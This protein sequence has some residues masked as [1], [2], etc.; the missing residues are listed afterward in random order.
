MRDGG[1]AADVGD[2]QQ[3]IAGRLD[4][5]QPGAAAAHDGLG[6]GCGEVGYLQRELAPAGQC[7]QGAMSAA[8]AVVGRE[9]AV[10]GAEE[11]QRQGDGRHS[12]AGDDAPNAAFELGQGR[13]EVIAGRVAGTG[14]VVPALAAESVELEGGGQVDGWHDRAM[15]EVGA[16]TGADGD[17]G[18]CR[19][20]S[21]TGRRSHFRSRR[22]AA[23]GSDRP[24]SGYRGRA[25]GSGSSRGAPAWKLGQRI[26]Q[27][28]AD[29]LSHLL[30]LLQEGVVAVGR[31][32]GGQLGGA[33]QAPLQFLHLGRRDEGVA[34]DCQQEGG[35]RDAAGI[36]LVQV[37]RFRERVV[38]VGGPVTRESFAAVI[39][40][41]LHLEAGR[42]AGEWRHGE[43]LLELVAGAVGGDRQGA[44]E[45]EG[46]A[47][48]A[49][50]STQRED[51]P[52]DY[53][54]GRGHG[55]ALV[56]R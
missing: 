28:R 42:L 39:E 3:G 16:D 53:P 19:T 11:L 33:S 6:A 44:R 9:D 1:Q 2:A 51:A 15:V 14:V 26:D 10:A 47:R 27:R 17:G 46:L 12:G 38:A 52:L 8:V 30:L 41:V 20:R 50:L 32:D 31:L 37:E 25:V 35:R 7:G 34:L 43:A 45:C 4:P 13:S 21:F 22:C 36:D 24:L 55:V 18:G 48:M 40:V 23:T 54:M 5:E 49:I 29:E 56:R